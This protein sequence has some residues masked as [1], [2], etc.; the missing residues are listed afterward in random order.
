MMMFGVSKNTSE[1]D[2]IWARLVRNCLGEQAGEI[3]VLCTFR[4]RFYAGGYLEVQLEL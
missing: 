1:C 3:G 4:D 2:T